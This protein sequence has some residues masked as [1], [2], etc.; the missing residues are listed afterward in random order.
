M[1]APCAVTWL[2]G[3]VPDVETGP[4]PFAL[5]AIAVLAPD[6]NAMLVVSEDEEEQARETGCE[7]VT[8]PG[9]GIGPDIPPTWEPPPRSSSFGEAGLSPNDVA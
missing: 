2:T 9:F 7:V 3:Y 1:S 5:S 4:S 8:Y 6:G